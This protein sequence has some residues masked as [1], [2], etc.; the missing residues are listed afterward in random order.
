VVGVRGGD[1]GRPPSGLSLVLVTGGS[2]TL[3]RHLVAALRGRDH[4]VRVLSRRPGAGT[5]RGDLTTGE[6]LAEAAAG[7][8]LILHAASDTRQGRGK[9]DLEQ[10]RRLLA[11]AAEARHLLYVS[12]V[13][14]DAIPFGYYRRK[15]ACEREIAASSIPHT[16]FRATQFHE[17]LAWALWSVRRLPVVPLPLAWPFQSVGVAEAAGRTVELLEGE[18]LGRAPD[19]GGPEV[20]T[21]REIV[22]AWRERHGRPRRTVNLRLPGRVSRGFREGGHTCPDHR[23]GRQTWAEFVRA[24]P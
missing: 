4:D 5:H 12:I 1:G 20:L 19:F 11:S 22:A 8:E 24:M 18:P 21:V 6:G 3:G 23:D 7:A 14:V 9:A 15:L 16:I 10:T 2:G 13:G 17:L